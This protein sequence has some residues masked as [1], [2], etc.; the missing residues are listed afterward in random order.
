MNTTTWAGLPPTATNPKA[1]SVSTSSSPIPRSNIPN[2]SKQVYDYENMDEEALRCLAALKDIR[3]T[4]TDTTLVD[5]A[6]QRLAAV[7]ENDKQVKKPARDFE[8]IVNDDHTYYQTTD[9]RS[10]QAKALFDQYR[11]QLDKAR[12]AYADA[13]RTEQARMAPAILDLEKHVQK[14]ARE[15]EQA[16]KAVRKAELE[17]IG[18]H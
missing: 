6:R 4:W 11:E 8:F 16:A 18:I 17:A 2:P 3:L 14:L 10:P 15:A 9:F 12:Q 13:D 1:K 5:E 7:A